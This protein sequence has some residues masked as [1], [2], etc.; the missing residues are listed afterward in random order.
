M[1]YKVNSS[2]VYVTA[3]FFHG[4]IVQ[5]P[6][7]SGQVLMVLADLLADVQ[8]ATK[9]RTMLGLDPGLLDDDDGNYNEA[10]ESD[11]E[12]TGLEGNELDDDIC[13]SRCDV[14]GGAATE[15]EIC[16]NVCLLA[17]HAIPFFCSVGLEIQGESFGQQQQQRLEV[18]MRH[19]SRA[20]NESGLGAMATWGSDNASEDPERLGKSSVQHPRVPGSTGPDDPLMKIDISSFISEVFSKAFREQQLLLEAAKTHMT[21]RQIEALS[22]VFSPTYI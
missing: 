12:E 11:D 7:P 22:S 18:A 9:R 14:K 19:G 15:G 4:L 10:S 17:S 1:D 21:A 6:P 2:F 16:A 13:S 20:D 8:E 3:G 5:A